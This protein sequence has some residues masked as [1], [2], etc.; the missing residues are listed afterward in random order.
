MN[1]QPKLV[2]PSELSGLRKG[3]LSRMK[4]TD[5]AGV[6]ATKWDWERALK[7]RSRREGMTAGCQHIALLMSTYADGDGSSIRPTAQTLADVSGKSRATVHEALRYLRERGWV[8]QVARGA[9]ASR[10]A[11]VYRLTIPP[12]PE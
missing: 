11:S 9:G 2:S 1:E 10:M 7:D 12:L 8:L 4:S 6:P 3:K 5:V